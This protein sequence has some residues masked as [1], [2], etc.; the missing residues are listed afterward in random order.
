MRSSVCAGYGDNCRGKQ[1]LKKTACTAVSVLQ[2]HYR[3]WIGCRRDS[4]RIYI[5]L[6][7]FI[8]DRD[9]DEAGR[10]APDWDLGE[11]HEDMK[12]SGGVGLRTLV[13]NLTVR[14]D[15]AASDE[16]MIAQVFIGQPWPKR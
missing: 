4:G 16:D 8:R 5:E 1:Y 6:E 12:W 2:R 15:F 10:V 3:L 9:L 11:L 14:F 7:P 13:N